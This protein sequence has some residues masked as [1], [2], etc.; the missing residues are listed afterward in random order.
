M[1]QLV[2]YYGTGKRKTAVARVY[3]RPGNGQVKV[4]GKDYNNLAEYL[5]GNDVWVLHAL[6]PL[7]VTD[8]NGQFDL[9]IRVNGGG[10]SGQ[11]GAIRLGIAR[12]LLQYDESLR[13]I[14]K[15]EGLLTR[16][17]RE[18]ERKKYGLKKARKSPQFSK[19]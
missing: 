19:R 11:A 2:E 3:L 18:V 6:K 5:R 15:K 7:E 16:D 4:N 8:L 13:P 14:L 9:I 12:A 1:A 10:L 17:P